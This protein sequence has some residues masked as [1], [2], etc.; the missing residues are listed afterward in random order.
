MLFVGTGNA[1][2]LLARRRPALEAAGSRTAARSGVLGGG[3]EAAHDLVVSTYGRGFY[4]MHD[5]TPLEQGV[6]EPAFTDAAALVAPRDGVPRTA[7]RQ[8][9]R[10][11]SC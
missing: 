11:R 2:V 7:R 6:M 10:L 9:A 3:A 1:S 5:I 8:R 4:I